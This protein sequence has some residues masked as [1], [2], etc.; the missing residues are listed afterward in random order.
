MREDN[1]VRTLVTKAGGDIGG[2]K[3]EYIA[4]VVYDS[5]VMAAGLY[6][7]TQLASQ[8]FVAGTLGASEKGLI[9]IEEVLA[10][11]FVFSAN[12]ETNDIALKLVVQT[13]KNDTTELIHIAVDGQN[14]S[15]TPEHPFW[16]PQKGWTKAVDLRAGDRLVDMGSVLRLKK[17][18]APCD[19]AKKHQW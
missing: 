9:P 6:A 3:G 14:I 17:L 15:T 5:V 10:G 12:P 4:G 2:S 18:D 1:I 19:A 11:S 16:I 7:G 13:F 8:C